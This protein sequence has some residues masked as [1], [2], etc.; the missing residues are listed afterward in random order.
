MAS[1]GLSCKAFTLFRNHSGDTAATGPAHGHPEF[2]SVM[3]FLEHK[4]VGSWLTCL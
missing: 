2:E 4:L 3:Q 1:G